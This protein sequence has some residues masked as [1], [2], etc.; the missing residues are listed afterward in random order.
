[1]FD[2]IKVARSYAKAVFYIANEQNTFDFWKSFLSFM[3][4][5]VK[6]RC[7]KLLLSNPTICVSFKVSFLK[8]VYCSNNFNDVMFDNFIN[9]VAVKKR[10]L[11]LPFIYVIFE[12]YLFS[13]EKNVQITITL[14]SLELKE[15]RSCIDFYLKKIFD[16]SV[17]T[18][19]GENVDKQIIG[20]VLITTTNNK[21]IDVTFSGNLRRLG[22]SFRMF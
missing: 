5:V 19:I 13:K 12:K 8:S 21:V 9:V 22:E 7:V 14:T 6:E 2:P 15:L 3:S 11:Y 20:G 17:V 1:M 4:I 10:L 16:G 18:V